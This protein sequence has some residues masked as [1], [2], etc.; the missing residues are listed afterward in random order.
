MPLFLYTEAMVY[1]DGASTA[2]PVEAYYS[3][4]RQTALEYPGNPSSSHG[5]GRAAHRKLEELRETAARLLEGEQTG[6][7]RGKGRRT[8]R[9]VFTSGGTESNNLVLT[10]FLNRPYTGQVVTTPMEHASAREPLAVLKRAGWTVAEASPDPGGIITPEALKKRLSRE[11]RLVS[12]HLVNSEMGA[13]QPI[14]ALVETVR[15]WEAEIGRP[16][17]FHTD[18]V[19]ALGKIPLSLEKLGVDSASFSAHKIGAPRGTGLLYCRSPLSPLYGGGGQEGGLRSGTE[20]L[21][22]IAGFASAMEDR[23]GGWQQAGAQ[24]AGTARAEALMEDLT[25]RIQG[26][27]GGRVLPKARLES[28]RNYSPWIL[29]AAFLPVPGE[30]LLRVLNEK[31][32]AVSTGSACS[33]NR[34]K[35]ERQRSLNALGLDGREALSAVRI[36]LDSSTTAQDINTLVSVLNRELPTLNRIKA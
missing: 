23:L 4:A 14:A 31:G 19:Q 1:L 29:A 5:L 3:L 28:P 12:I 22:G 9:I 17:H 30:V 25:A 2:L 32:I 13:I 36:S 20:N 24:P 8:D 15:E 6:T 33:S 18:A 11:T 27:P 10:G 21:P 35:K 16:I 7:G 26:L 34:R